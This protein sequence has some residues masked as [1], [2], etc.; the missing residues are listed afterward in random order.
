MKTIRDGVFE[1]NSSSTHSISFSRKSENEIERIYPLLIEDGVLYPQ[2]LTEH[3]N[4]DIN[5]ITIIICDTTEKKLAFVANLI[6]Q[7]SDCYGDLDLYNIGLTMLI[8][9][10]DISNII[11]EKNYPVIYNDEDDILTSEDTF[12]EDLRK[13][14]TDIKTPENIITY[15]VSPA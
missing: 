14:I 7:Y 15:I 5:Y 13:L 2:R 11:F 9:E 6:H 3:Y 1:T 12:M 10:F 8:N 4:I